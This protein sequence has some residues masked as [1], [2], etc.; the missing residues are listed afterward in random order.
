MAETPTLHLVLLTTT[1]DS[2]ELV[3]NHDME[4]LDGLAATGGLTT[5]VVTALTVALEPNHR[6]IVNNSSQIVGTLPVT[7][8]VGSVIQMV[9]KGS[10]GWKVAQRA[11]QQIHVGRRSTTLGTAGSLEAAHPHDTV[12]LVCIEANTTWEASSRV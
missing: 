3:V 10:G 6:Y 2:K 8:G 7:A 12:T 1:Q 5:V 11:G 4:I 9:G